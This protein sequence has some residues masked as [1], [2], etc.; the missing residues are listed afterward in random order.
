MHFLMLC[1]QKNNFAFFPLNRYQI[2]IQ[3]KLRQT[4]KKII[5]TKF[6]QTFCAIFS[7]PAFGMF[8]LWLFEVRSA[9]FYVL[10]RKKVLFY[11]SGTL[12]IAQFQCFVIRIPMMKKQLG[13]VFCYRVDAP[14][15]CVIALIP[16]RMIFTIIT[17][18]CHF[19]KSWD[20]NLTRLSRLAKKN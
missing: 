15:S 19:I 5:D 18:F 17:N 14:Q 10:F 1:Q 4:V 13:S 12:K 16:K 7:F 2:M 8:G 9:E 20:F 11:K 6:K 3:L